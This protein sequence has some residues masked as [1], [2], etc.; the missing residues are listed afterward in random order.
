MLKNIAKSNVQHRNFK[1][2]KKFYASQNDYPVMKIYDKTSN[3]H[4]ATGSF[5]SSTF[6]RTISGSIYDSFHKHPM[7][8][9]IRQ[10][11]FLE[12]DFV[13]ELY[14]SSINSFTV[15]ATMAC[16]VIYALNVFI[17]LP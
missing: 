2:Y 3:L 12:N 4:S 11:Y 1:V 6:E 15:L 14:E 5:D 8:K 7:Y 16:S 17:R 9:S 10:K 13:A